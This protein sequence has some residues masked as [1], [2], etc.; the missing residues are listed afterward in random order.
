MRFLLGSGD[1]SS[2][3]TVLVIQTGSPELL[4]QAV[5]LIR[6][7]L[8]RAALTV[9]L[10]RNMRDKVPVREGV[11]YLENTGSKRGL[12]ARLRAR[13]FDVAC[14]L[15]VNH[16]GYWKLKLLPFLIGARHVLAVNEHMGWFPINLRDARRLA[17][18]LRWR[19]G[20]Q[21]RSSRTSVELAKSAVAA[22]A[23]P[24]AIGWLI[25]YEKLAS[26][27]ADTAWKRNHRVR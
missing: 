21:A 26:L 27:R 25:A 15:Y 22:V 24:L 12:T 18:H 13:R 1:V 7:Q 4:T 2:A 20:S 17:G 11:E 23:R 16:P 10:Q 19:A 14:V 3:K 8:P 9:L 6:T 5:D